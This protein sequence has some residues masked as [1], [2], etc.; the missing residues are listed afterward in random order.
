MPGGASSSAIGARRRRLRRRPRPQ[1]QERLRGSGVRVAGA[2]GRHGEAGGAAA[3]SSGLR[4]QVDHGRRREPLGTPPRRDHLRRSGR[5][6]GRSRPAARGPCRTR[7]CRSRLAGLAVRTSGRRPRPPPR[8]SCGP[9]TR[10]AGRGGLRPARARGRRS[11]QPST[12]PDSLSERRPPA[13]RRAD[14]RVVEGGPESLQGQA[15]PRLRTLDQCPRRS[16]RDGGGG[17]GS[18]ESAVR[19]VGSASHRAREGTHD[20]PR[21]ND[22]DLRRESG[23]ACPAKCENDPLSHEDSRGSPPVSTLTQPQRRLRRRTDTSRAVIVD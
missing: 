9:A 18:P 22:G 15:S 2:A 7:R 10:L 13:P 17:H 8:V 23:G 4:R 14:A 6:G 3:S 12:A 11:S 1:R 16:R 19:D 20:V 5:L 21:G